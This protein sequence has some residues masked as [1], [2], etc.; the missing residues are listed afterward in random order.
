LYSDIDLVVFGQWESLPLRTLEQ[1]LLKEGITTKETIK[2]LDK[3]SV[4]FST[5]YSR[6]D[7]I[8]EISN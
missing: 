3:A 7:S 8:V 4:S 5:I 6:V 2:V 1:A